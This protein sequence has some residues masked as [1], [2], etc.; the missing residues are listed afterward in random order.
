MHERGFRVILDG[1]KR[2][3]KNLENR[4][5]KLTSILGIKGHEKNL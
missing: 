5:E 2:R 4:Q 3:I 1:C